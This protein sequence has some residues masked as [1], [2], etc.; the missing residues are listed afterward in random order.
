MLA[1]VPKMKQNTVDERVESQPRDGLS[2]KT[3]D[4]YRY[5]DMKRRPVLKGLLA[6]GLIATLFTGSTTAQTGGPR[7]P[8]GNS[9]FLVE[10]DGIQTAAFSRV[11]LPAHSVPVVEFRNGSDPGSYQKNDG[12]SEHDPL[13]LEWGI[14]T[15]S[16]ELYEWFREADTGDIE[17]ARRSMA[18]ILLDQRGQET[19]RW[20][21]R[22]AWPS[23]YIPPT[24]DA[25]TNE[26]AVERLEISHEG[27]EKDLR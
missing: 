24:L 27:M 12:I 5:F 16:D 15:D 13:L 2:E 22:N 19:A 25:H 17:N 18:V 11:A 20:N 7:R 14:T 26:I 21:F 9:R 6:T 23:K 3:A 8:I 4:N 1:R 10:I